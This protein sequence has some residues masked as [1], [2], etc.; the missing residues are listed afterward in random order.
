MTG[1]T[2]LAFGF[3]TDD[4]I[5]AETGIASKVPVN[6]TAKA[7]P[8]TRVVFFKNDRRC[9]LKS[10]EYNDFFEFFLR[11]FSVNMNSSYIFLINID[12]NICCEKR[13]YLANMSLH[14]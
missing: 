7:A 10:F 6:E 4:L 8:A 14:R 5:F 9:S 3:I 11:E 13:L 12:I 2:K 1:N